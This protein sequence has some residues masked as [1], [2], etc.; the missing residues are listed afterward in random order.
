MPKWL[1][2]CLCA[3]LCFSL[4]SAC[5][6]NPNKD[7]SEKELYETAKKSIKLRNFSQ[8]TL[9]LEELESRFPFG[10]YAEQAQL[11]LIYARYSALDLEGAI[12]AADRFI[13]LHPQSPSVDYAFYIRGIANYNL[14][15]GI[16][17]QYFSAVD[18]TSRDPGNMRSAF[19]DFSQLINRFPESQ[20][21]S[22]AQQRMILIRNRL[23]A[24]ELHAARYYIRRE[25]Y[26]AAANRA[27]HVVTNYPRSPSV[28]EALAMMV[29]L[30]QALK[31]TQ[32]A[33]DAMLVLKENYPSGIAFDKNGKF[34]SQFVKKES[35]SLLSVISFGIFD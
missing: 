22:D 10:K 19:D 27:A 7:A 1:K 28:E 31:L 4:L 6:S 16:A 3:C 20:Y 8:A 9:A 14:D 12:L 25:A 23:A 30:Y 2:Y 18:I 33:E 24:Y 17:S 13:R 34:I 21:A 26:I 32:Q 5:S 35:R 29:E 11:D 15:V